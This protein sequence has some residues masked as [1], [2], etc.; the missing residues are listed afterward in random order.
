MG[1]SHI[2]QDSRVQTTKEGS[3]SDIRLGT[4]PVVTDWLVCLHL[5]AIHEKQGGMSSAGILQ[6]TS[7]AVRQRFGSSQRSSTEY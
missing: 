2:S 4:D 7:T 3:I 5:Q 1:G 6:Q